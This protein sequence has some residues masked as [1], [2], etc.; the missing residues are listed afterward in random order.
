MFAPC[1]LHSLNLTIA[2]P[3]TGT[4]RM[5]SD[6]S[7]T[8]AA[9]CLQKKYLHKMSFGGTRA[10]VLVVQFRTAERMQC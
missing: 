2:R 10:L 5:R 8:Q 7:F 1:P 4:A 6:R 9:I 3:K